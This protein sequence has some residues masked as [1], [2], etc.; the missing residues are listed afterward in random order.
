MYCFY[1][2]FYFSVI[3]YQNIN[4]G[5][6]FKIIATCIF[7][8]RVLAEGQRVLTKN[9][10]ECRV[11]FN[12]I[13]FCSCFSK[14]AVPINY[15]DNLVYYFRLPSCICVI[16]SS[17]KLTITS[18]EARHTQTKLEHGLFRI[19]KCL[20]RVFSFLFAPYLGWGVILGQVLISAMLAK[21][22]KLLWIWTSLTKS[23]WPLF[24]P[25]LLTCWKL[26]GRLNALVGWGLTLVIHST[27]VE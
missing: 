18:V 21:S 15:N 12:L 17:L 24:K 25:W 19:I 8:G 23:F 6:F 20:R 4:F 9:C 7:G 26:R 11:S 3:F 14:Y 16:H 1:L 13:N 5:A 27:S 22:L 10:R 2:Y